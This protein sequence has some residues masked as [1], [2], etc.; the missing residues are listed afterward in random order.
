[1]AE[2]KQ[3]SISPL[4]SKENYLWMLIGGV[5]VALGMFL[6]SGGRSNDPN[7]FDTSGVYSPVRIT[8]APIVILLGLGIEIYAI[9]KKP[10]AA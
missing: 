10:K 1:M 6:M 2:Q 8:V 5:V 9:F 7:V 3:K 4:F